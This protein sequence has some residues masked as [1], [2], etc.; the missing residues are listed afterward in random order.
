MLAGPVNYGTWG[1]RD[2]LVSY[3]SKG[4][5]ELDGCVVIAGPTNVEYDIKITRGTA[6]SADPGRAGILT[7]SP[8]IVGG[9]VQ[10]WTGPAY[11][12]FSIPIAAHDI[13]CGLTPGQA[14]ELLV[15]VYPKIDN[16]AGAAALA[17]IGPDATGQG[18]L[19]VALVS[20]FV[21]RRVRC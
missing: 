11:L 15:W 5:W 9:G 4:V 17:V 8:V 18:G 19:P 1:F 21:V 6:L 7:D 13:N 16:S 12:P 10:T 2:Q 14:T 3:P 20:S